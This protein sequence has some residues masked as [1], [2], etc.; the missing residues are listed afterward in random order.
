MRI[1]L[2][3]LCLALGSTSITL[4][5][6]PDAI[7]QNPLCP[8][9]LTEE[10]A[11]QIR[12]GTYPGISLEGIMGGTRHG[13]A[14]FRWEPG[15]RLVQGDLKNTMAPGDS[16]EQMK[17]VCLYVEARSPDSN[18]IMFKIRAK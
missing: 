8:K 2:I 16:E 13:R 12:A 6:A 14:G 15:L 1:P 9:E 5:A 17:D 10:I 3:A 7:A 4:N 11:N 18:F